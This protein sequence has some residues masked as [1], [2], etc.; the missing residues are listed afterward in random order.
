MDNVIR[1]RDHS[2]AACIVILTSVSGYFVYRA[3]SDRHELR[4]VREQNK[5]ISQ[6][7]KSLE[8]SF[9]AIRNYTQT[10]DGFA[11]AAAYPGALRQRDEL[12]LVVNNP[13]ALG[14]FGRLTLT[15][16]ARGESKS[17]QDKFSDLERFT[18]TMA[19]IDHVSRDT[20]LVVRR[21]RSL[22]T[23]FKYNQDMIRSIPSLKPTDGVITSEFGTRMSPFEGKRHFHP[24]IDIAAV[25]GA[26]IIAPADGTV[27]FVGDFENLGNSILIDHGAGI[28]TRY[29]HLSRYN[30]EVGQT[31]HR[32]DAVAFV[33]NTGRSTGPHLHYEIWIRNVAVNPRDFFFDLESK[34]NQKLVNAKPSL[35]IKKVAG[36]TGMGGDE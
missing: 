22:A 5:I 24:G 36:L 17:K 1:V 31:I 3:A 18:A 8:D 11:S 28:L 12:S 25:N 4:K 33:G 21:L 13:E 16:K 30:V 9:K 14:L 35:D 23:L 19:T 27:T 32:G 20:D 29:G 26:P 2:V 34:D 7:V 15:S 6:H 10:A